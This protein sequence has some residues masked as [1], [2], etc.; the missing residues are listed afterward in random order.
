MNRDHRTEVR[1]DATIE[2]SATTAR[3]TEGHHAE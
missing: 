2:Q 3:A 1:R